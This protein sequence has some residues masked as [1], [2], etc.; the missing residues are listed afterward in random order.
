MTEEIRSESLNAGPATAA[1]VFCLG[2]GVL[3]FEI[4]ST[5][6]LSVAVGNQGISAILGLAMLGFGAAAAF[7]GALSRERAVV[8]RDAWLPGLCALGSLSMAGVFAVATN[9]CASSSLTIDRLLDAGGVDL[10]ASQLYGGIFPG[11]FLL[12]ALMSLPHFLCGVVVVLL[13][14]C[15]RSGSYAPLYGMDLL[16]AAVGSLVCVFAMEYGDYR[17][18]L[19]LTLALPVV[20]GFFLIRHR[21]VSWRLA[22]A[23][24]LAIG[25][26]LVFQPALSSSLEPQP[27]LRM[28]AGFPGL[29]ETAVEEWHAWNSYSRVSDIIVKDGRGRQLRRF[30][31]FGTGQGRATFD[32]SGNGRVGLATVFGVPRKALI[33]FAGVGSEVMTLDRLSQGG[34]DITAVEINRQMLHRALMSREHGLDALF[35]KGN[36]HL[37]V[38]EARSFLEQDESRYDLILAPYFGSAYS[39][40]WASSVELAQYTFTREA[41]E[42]MISRLEPGGMVVSFDV[43]KVVLLANLR[44]LFE[45]SGRGDVSRCVVIS[46]QGP[47]DARAFFHPEMTKAAQRSRAWGTPLDDMVLFFKPSGFSAS[48]TERFRA[49]ARER[50]LAVLYDPGMK[51]EGNPYRQILHA[52]R[53]REVLAR[54]QQSGRVRFS[55]RT[56]DHQFLSSVY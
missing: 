56:D 41:Y 13:F 40:L 34:T 25:Q 22:L 9:L 8:L 23:F 6:V 54:L 17:W 38:S 1:G 27:N 3:S 45:R 11:L 12:G 50:R 49:F 36:I 20:A 42:T 47:L 5:R 35:S 52:E 18:P 30:F 51:D 31:T 43:N 28:L 29:G 2:W 37:R 53:W 26:C 10:V 16:G 15:V 39:T 4:L 21:A 46:S 14:R 24:V 33:L 44:D 48:E 7:V 55:P 32:S 19:A